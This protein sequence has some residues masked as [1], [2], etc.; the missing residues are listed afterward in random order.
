MNRMA[1]K[2]LN[3]R[4]PY[5]VLYGS[6]PDISMIYRFK[7]YDRIYS[8][9]DDSRGGDEFPSQSNEFSGRFVGF[10]EIVGHKLTYKSW[11]PR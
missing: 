7:F 8:K 2:S 10:S 11:S 3:W 5:E 1:L 9:R 4:T 6:T